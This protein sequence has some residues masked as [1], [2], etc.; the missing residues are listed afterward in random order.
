MQIFG[1]PVLGKRGVLH[2]EGG[3]ERASADQATVTDAH[4]TC[5][6]AS[7]FSY[8]ALCLTKVIL[9]MQGQ[10]ELLVC[11]KGIYP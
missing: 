6:K 9:K 4:V 5:F 8:I 7:N 11:Y 1:W 10:W 3:G 2:S